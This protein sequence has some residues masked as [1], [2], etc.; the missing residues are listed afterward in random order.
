MSRDDY[1]SAGIRRQVAARANYLC[2]YCLLP[3]DISFIGH[4]IDHIISLKHGGTNAETNLAYTC[5]TCNRFKGA[6]IASIDW[7]TGQ[8]VRFF[9]PRTDLWSEHF[10][11][12][13]AW[14]EPLT[15]IGAV[16]ARILRFNDKDRLNERS[17]FL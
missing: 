7:E 3:D 15:V 12:N 2:E 5:P 8:L 14:I 1:L 11:F 4:E 13:G 9:N 6:D 10:R 16:T 17:L